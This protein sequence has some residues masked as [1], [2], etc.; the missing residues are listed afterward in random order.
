[1]K[2]LGKYLKEKYMKISNIFKNY[3]RNAYRPD[4]DVTDKLRPVDAVY[5]QSL[6]GVMIWM[7]EIGRL[8]IFL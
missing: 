7:V 3:I 8:D 6:I 2:N 5:Y 1:M 4:I